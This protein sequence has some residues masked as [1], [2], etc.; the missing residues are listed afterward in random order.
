MALLNTVHEMNKIK[1][2]IL[3]L[4]ENIADKANVNEM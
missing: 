2:L 4:R 3:K 1:V